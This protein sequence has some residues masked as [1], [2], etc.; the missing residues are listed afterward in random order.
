MMNSF[1]LAGRFYVISRIVIEPAIGYT[2]S[3]STCERSIPK[4]QAN[5]KFRYLQWIDA[6]VAPCLRNKRS[7]NVEDIVLIIITDSF[8]STGHYLSL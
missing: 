1:S 7:N 6:N 8:V 3:L 5:R 2:R 4:M